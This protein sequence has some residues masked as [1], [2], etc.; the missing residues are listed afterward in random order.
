M[1]PS[2]FMSWYQECKDKESLDLAHASFVGMN[3]DLGHVFTKERQTYMQALN[4]GTGML[5]G[6][7]GDAEI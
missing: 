2:S 4:P 6:D 3:R 5:A 7:P 1:S